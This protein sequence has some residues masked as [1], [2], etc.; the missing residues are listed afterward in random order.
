LLITALN[1]R[2]IFGWGRRKILR[3]YVVFELEKTGKSNPWHIRPSSG[4]GK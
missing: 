3:I 2:M 4:W 1:N